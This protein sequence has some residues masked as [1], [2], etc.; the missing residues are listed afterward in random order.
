LPRRGG[1]GEKSKFIIFERSRDIHT[2][3]S[4]RI[5]PSEG[6]SSE[7]EPMSFGRGRARVEKIVDSRRNANFPI[8][9]GE[10]ENEMDNQYQN[11]HEDQ[12]KRTQLRQSSD[13][14]N[15]G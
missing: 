1:G 11:T 6:D 2:R 10:E 15:D 12:K 7:D 13:S 4:I 3:Y 8:K 5:T 9:L 14:D